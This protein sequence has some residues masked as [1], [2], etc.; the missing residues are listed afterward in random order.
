MNGAPASLFTLDESGPEHSHRSLLAKTLVVGVLLALFG[1]L[2]W[3][4]SF[5]WEVN[6]QYAYGWVVPVLAIYLAVRR[7]NSRPFPQLAP[8]WTWPALILCLLTLAPVWLPIA[9]NLSA[10]WNSLADTLCLS[11][12]LR[13]QCGPLATTARARFGTGL[14][15]V[16]RRI[17]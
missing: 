4:L 12:L 15:A 9:G 17:G 1:L 6:P 16:C 3:H 8:G 5:F 10:R 14:D 13:A 11:D 2:T 7:W